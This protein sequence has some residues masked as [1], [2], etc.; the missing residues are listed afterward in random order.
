[1]VLIVCLQLILEQPQSVP[2]THYY[3]EAYHKHNIYLD[4]EK[5]SLEREFYFSYLARKERE[6][7]SWVAW[8]VGCGVLEKQKVAMRDLDDWIQ[9]FELI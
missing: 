1:M 4:F 2:Q 6:R 9:V 8:D 5:A 7:E 3:L